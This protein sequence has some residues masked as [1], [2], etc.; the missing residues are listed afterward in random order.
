MFTLTP[1]ELARHLKA[2]AARLRFWREQIALLGHWT[3]A[4][5][6]GSKDSPTPQQLLGEDLNPER[7]EAQMAALVDGRQ[8]SV[9]ALDR[10]LAVQAE[11][12]R[13]AT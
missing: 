4:A 8:A 5:W 12:R 10:A 9:E 6:R 1:R 2:H 3:F 7:A 13:G 11:R